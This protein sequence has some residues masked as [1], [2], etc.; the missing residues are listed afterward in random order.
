MKDIHNILTS[1]SNEW[2]TKDWLFKSLDSEF[3][4][5]LDPCSTHENAKCTKHYTIEDDGLSKDWSGEIVFMNPPYGREIGKWIRKAYEEAS[6]GAVICALISCRPDTAYWHD[7]IFPHASQI[8]FFRG[9]VGYG[10]TDF[11]PFPSCVVIFG[12]EYEDRI[13]YNYQDKLS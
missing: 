5:T 2:T 8:R 12:K 13:V 10:E 3:H 1:N 9:R 6:N 7:Y 4:F 11:S